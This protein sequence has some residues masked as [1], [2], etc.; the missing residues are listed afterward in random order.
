MY[1]KAIYDVV[2]MR[3]IIELPDDQVLALADLCRTEKI[4]RAEAI[5]RALGEMLSRKQA[6]RR[7][8]AF[9]A[10]THRGDSRAVVEQLRQEWE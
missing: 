4:S 5:R 6:H 1:P 10:W 3:T 2:I 8:S 9:G 7:E